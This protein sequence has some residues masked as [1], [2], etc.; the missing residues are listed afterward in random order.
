MPLGWRNVISREARV[1]GMEKSVVKF[2]DVEGFG[3]RREGSP[4]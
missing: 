2:D 1:V 3:A 4:P